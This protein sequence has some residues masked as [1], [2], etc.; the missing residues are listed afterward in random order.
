MFFCCDEA[1]AEQEKLP[2]P[3]S[4][5]FL[6]CERVSDKICASALRKLSA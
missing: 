4:W 6:F 5:I 3:L 1:E 2:N